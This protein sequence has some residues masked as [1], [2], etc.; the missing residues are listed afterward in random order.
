MKKCGPFIVIL[1]IVLLT[2]CSQDV[3]QYKNFEKG[4]S[5]SYSAKWEK[6]LVGGREIFFLNPKKGEESSFR[7]NINIM[8]QD[9]SRDPMNLGSYHELTKNQIEEALSFNTISSEK[10]IV[11]SGFP[12]KEII[13]SIPQDI[14]K[15]RHLD[16]KL[17][18]VY[19]IKDNF[20]YLITYTALKNE[21]DKYSASAN[22][23]FS[24]FK[25]VKN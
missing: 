20:A 7:T 17:K 5:F 16:L 11:V 22:T 25:V 9:L 14:S 15:G 1:N 2:G 4:Y 3:K 8:I 10:N 19:F 24:T 18:Q 13:Y 23:V 21:F 6:K 12:A